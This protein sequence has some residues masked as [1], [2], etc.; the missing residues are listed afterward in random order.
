[1][2][3][4]EKLRKQWFWLGHDGK[5]HHLGEFVSDR[6]AEEEADKIQGVHFLVDWSA[7]REWVN[8]EHKVHNQV[9]QDVSAEF[10]KEL[11]E[12]HSHAH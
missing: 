10:Q 4:I 1:M 11:D 5:M 12:A 6:E 9:L 8:L 2:K 3:K 7:L